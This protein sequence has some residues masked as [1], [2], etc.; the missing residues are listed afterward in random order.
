MGTKLKIDFSYNV[1][2]IR[3]VSA[4]HRLSV[5]QLN[6]RKAKWSHYIALN[7]IFTR[8]VLPPDLLDMGCQDFCNII[9]KAAEKTIPSGH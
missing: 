5:Q 2:E 8:T 7:N 4:K 1:T 6:F 3:F 9:S